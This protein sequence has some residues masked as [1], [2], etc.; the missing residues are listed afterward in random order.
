MSIE[1]RQAR[2]I[3]GPFD[4]RWN[5]ES[6]TRQCRIADLSEGGCFIDS[7]ANNTVGSK[8]SVEFI[9]AGHSFHLRS[10]VVYLDKAQGFA[11]RFTGND[12]ELIQTLSLA[13]GM[14]LTAHQ[15]V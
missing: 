4:G 6:G 14:A 13:I 3:A 12:P 8:V 5:G 7:L 10:E 2:R 9:F 1:R 15:P 11:V